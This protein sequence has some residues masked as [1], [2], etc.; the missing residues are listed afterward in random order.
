MIKISRPV[1]GGEYMRRRLFNRLDGMK[2]F[3][4]SWISAPA[5]SGKSTLVSG[6]AEYENVPCLWYQLDSADGDPAAFFY[7]L[8]LAV[9]KAVPGR[10]TGLPLFT[11]E[12][13]PGAS[14]F[15]SVYFDEL[16]RRL[17]KPTLMVFDNYQD[18]PLESPVHD[19]LQRAFSMLP[20]EIRA[21]VISRNDPPP[22]F[23]RLKAGRMLDILDWEEMK[24]TDAEAAEIVRMRLGKGLESD[25]V[26]EIMKLSGGWAAG[27]TLL[28]E[29]MKRKGLVMRAEGFQAPEEVFDYF[30]QEVFNGLAGN[31]RDFMMKTAYLPEMTAA[32]A[33]E[34]TGDPS[35]EKILSGMCRRNYFISERFK[36]SHSYGYHPLY[37]RFLT[38]RAEEDIDPQELAAVRR[39]AALILERS[40]RSGEA[41]S[42][43]R[44]IGDYEGIAGIVLAHGGEMMAQGRFQSLQHWMEDLPREFIDDRPW[45]LYWKGMSLLAFQ[46]LQA[47]ALFETAF[48]LFR[49]GGDTVGAV[50]SASAAMNAIYM[51]MEDYA[52]LDRWFGVVHRLFLETGSFPSPE[53]EAWVTSGMV[54]ALGLRE[55]DHPGAE[56]WS[57]RVYGLAENPATV[58]PKANA[59]HQLFW[60]G[61]MRKGLPAVER[62]WLELR[63][64]A[65]GKNAHP[66]VVITAKRLES[67]YHQLAGMAENCVRA[68]DE[69]LEIARKH[70]ILFFD[71]IFMI[72]KV[73]CLLDMSDT[74]R[75]APIL[76]SVLSSAACRSR[77]G[78]AACLMYRSRAALIEGEFEKALALADELLPLAKSLNSP[79]GL[80]MG[81]LR[82]AL[83]LHCLGKKDDA[84]RDLSEVHVL[85]QTHAS[86]W[87]R[88]FA[89]YH[90]AFFAYDGGHG[91]KGLESLRQSLE[92]AR[93]TGY[94]YC[95]DDHPEITSV[96]CLKALSEGIEK[97]YA[98]EI[99]RRRNL[100]PPSGKDMEDLD[101]WPYPVT[102]RTLGRFEIERNG[103]PVAFT[104][105]VQKKPLELLKAVIAMGGNHVPVERLTDALWP[106][107]E[108][109][110]AHKSFEVTL[111]RLRK[112][113]GFDDILICGAGR[114]A[115]DGRRC[116]VDSLVLERILDEA[117]NVDD[118]DAAELS[119]K[120]VSLYRGP[121]LPSDGGLPWTSSRRDTLHD[122]VLRLLMKAGRH[123]ELSGNWEKALEFY[124]RGIEADSLAESFYQRRM[125]CLRELGHHAEAVK[126]YQAC[127]NCLKNQ[128]GIAPSKTTD[129]I[130]ESIKGNS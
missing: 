111:S 40:G 58:I 47:K 73:A 43:L 3:K 75:A 82:K 6:Y 45:L 119:R 128:L 104:G 26:H 22:P 97:E 123:F 34:L 103:S 86:R 29:V 89:L 54:A 113:L 20:P 66:M 13:L 14:A 69:G 16:Y 110:L 12:Y 57:E 27:L 46:P 68:S 84:L 116:R 53:I 102:I 117:E 51:G 93:N 78:R 107:A 41:V 15:T 118:N 18:V 81:L 79:F 23:I 10:K 42:L 30:A 39:S 99:I 101:H 44:D 9:K 7:Y 50:L 36:P 100:A 1:P 72:S 55:I 109:D 76:D 90:E 112:L 80:G 130:Y 17:K 31:V 125:V 94:V 91:E 25:T 85:A 122:G 32:M 4:V 127:R 52:P 37:R 87:L 8:G 19:I 28:T 105:K 108:G 106:E 95:T 92:I 38:A 64:M 59:L 120:A 88:M 115:L 61:A 49:N 60:F 83:A 67:M 11:P 21:V 70:G 33:R 74:R 35:A 65:T 129:A 56:E 126:T 77:H 96:L 48:S 98:G 63:R 5:G 71:F 24:L 2:A 62:A 121:F 124:S 114:V